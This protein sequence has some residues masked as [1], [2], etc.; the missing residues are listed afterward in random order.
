MKYVS[1]VLALLCIETC[2]LLAAERPIAVYTAYHIKEGVLKIDPVIIFIGTESRSKKCH[3][4]GIGWY[5]Y[6]TELDGIPFVIQQEG[7]KI[8]K[9][10]E[11][12]CKYK[13]GP[14]FEM[15][16][17]SSAGAACDYV[18]VE[19]VSYPLEKEI[20]LAK[21]IQ[22]QDYKKIFSEIQNQKY[23]KIETDILGFDAFGKREVSSIVCGY[24]NE[25]MTSFIIDYKDF[26]EM[27]FVRVKMTD[28]MKRGL[29]P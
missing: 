12:K 6:I 23:K 9:K 17:N 24:I 4:A 10:T 27:C 2:D 21:D 11:L 26:P 22:Q 14:L 29:D 8:H 1:L 16:N 18:N 19:I 7:D 13:F 20:P 15:Y 3:L 28:E 25:E 5:E